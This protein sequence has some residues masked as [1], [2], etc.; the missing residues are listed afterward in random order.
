MSDFEHISSVIGKVAGSP[1]CPRCGEPIKEL[2]IV[3]GPHRGGHWARG[4]CPKC[5]AFIKWIS[6]PDDLKN[7]KRSRK[8]QAELIRKFSRGWCEACRRSKD[9]LPKPETLEAHHVIPVRDHGDDTRENIWIVC[10]PCHRLIE[11]YR[12]YLGHYHSG[13]AA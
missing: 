3:P 7:A 8:G 5:G 4:E 13:D 9:Q 11:H 2:R 12:T 1:A 10:T 6:K